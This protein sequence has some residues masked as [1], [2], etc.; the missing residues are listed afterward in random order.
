MQLA[1]EGR[2]IQISN[3]FGWLYVPL[4]AIKATLAAIKSRYALPVAI[5]LCLLR[6][7]GTGAFL[8]LAGA[9]TAAVTLS[10][11]DLSRA[12]TDV[13]LGNGAT[14]QVVSRK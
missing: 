14:A 5:R 7:S 6:K 13:E 12:A 4:Q 8:H 9:K 11:N 1:K 3:I 10:A 2:C